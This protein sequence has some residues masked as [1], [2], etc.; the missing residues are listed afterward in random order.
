MTGSRPRRSE[1][2]GAEAFFPPRATT[3][4]AG[5]KARSP[6]SEPGER[7][8]Q[9][10]TFL[11]DKQLRQKILLGRANRTDIL[12]PL[13]LVSDPS[14]KDI[15][16]SFRSTRSRPNR[17]RRTTSPVQVEDGQ[18]GM[19]L[20]RLLALGINHHEGLLGPDREI[21]PHRRRGCRPAGPCASWPG[22]PA[23]RPGRRRGHR[24]PGAAPHHRKGVGMVEVRGTWQWIARGSVEAGFCYPASRKW[25]DFGSFKGGDGRVGEAD[26]YLP[27]PVP[28]Q[29]L[30]WSDRVE[31][32]PELPRVAG[33]VKHVED[34]LAVEPLVL[35]RLERSLPHAVN[36]PSA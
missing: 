35:Q 7:G 30:V 33:Q 15:G 22:P 18:V 11:A 10:R 31:L 24:R 27:Q 34:V 4:A 12:M 17:S 1:K 6:P 26:V 19:I 3:T 16:T 32:D 23:L 20:R 8:N 28:R 9:T 14:T 2:E 21:H 5:F 29:R 13:L 25:Q 36:A